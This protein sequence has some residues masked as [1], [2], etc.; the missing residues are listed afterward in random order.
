[1]GGET[2]GVDDLGPGSEHL[3]RN[4]VEHVPAIVYIGSNDAPPNTLYISPQIADLLGYSPEDWIHGQDWPASVH[5]EDAD[6]VIGAWRE[7][8]ET[9]GPFSEEYRILHR[10]GHVVWGRDSARLIRDGDGRP[11]FWQ[12]VFQD[13]SDGNRAERQSRRSERRYRALVEQLPAIV[14]VDSDDLQ[15]RSL[16]VSPNVV[17]LLGYP[18]Q[19]Y[20]DDPDLW[21]RSMHPDD[22][23]SVLADWQEA[24]R[25]SEPFTAEYRIVRP[26]G[27]SLWVRDSSVPL[28]DKEGDVTYWQGVM[29]DIT[30]LTRAERELHRSEARYR[31]LVEGIPAVIYEMDPDDER[32]T[33]YVSPQVVDV[34]GYS[35]QEWLDQPDIWTELLHP[36][37]REIELAALDLHN[38]TGEPW[39]RDYRLIANDGRVVWV[40]DQAALVQ[41]EPGRREW[42]GVML[43]ITA[44]K[45]AE[46]RLMRANDELE[47][48]VLARTS[49]LTEANEMMALE[50][51]ERRRV[52]QE[53]RESQ[54]RY[55]QLVEHLP[56]V[57]FTWQAG[58]SRFDPS[59]AYISPQLE[60][61]LGYTPAEWGPDDRTWRERLHP[62][63]GARVVAAVERSAETGAPFNE[64]YRLFA[65]DG[66]LVWILDRSSMLS[67]T[68]DGKPDLFQGVMLDITSTRAAEAKAD[69]AQH[70]F[71]TLA[72]QG[73]VISYLFEKVDIP[74][75]DEPQPAVTY[76]SPQMEA[77]LGYPRER[78]VDEPMLWIHIIHPDDLSRILDES[79]RAW[80]TGEPWA[81]DMRMIAQDG[82]VVWLYG[83]GRCI[84]RDAQGA[85]KA[86]HG[87][88]LDISR[89]KEAE[90]RLRA[91]ELHHR[92]LLARIPGIP[93]IELQ[94]DDSSTDRMLFL[95][96]QVE[97]ILGW[98]PEELLREPG[99]FRRMV[100]PDDRDRVLA[101]SAR[102]DATG[103]PWDCEYRAT[104]KDGRI[105][106]MQSRGYR[107]VE[108]ERT[109]WY[110]IT[111]DITA[112]MEREATAA[113]SGSEVS[114]SA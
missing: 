61:I 32:R 43:D 103:E 38:Q 71:A 16:Y 91:S 74:G 69:A 20:L 110:G 67:R 83:Q 17:D 100:H 84:E 59:R 7:A 15:P 46:E 68:P 2:L 112:R 47:F 77:V 31:T 111:M 18:V 81:M 37:D 85:P 107:V 98:T 97:E 35:R 79:V 102:C 104:T 12:G 86:F 53:L 66:R 78:F 114:P 6:R 41:A 105:V 93:W 73:P 1:M 51:G 45:T 10:D 72:E 60:T 99:H 4:L 29:L 89:R 13:V 75:H 3:F 80:I 25:T 42:H 96:D 8:V 52:E 95:G 62:H 101:L 54:E 109:L 11:V 40:R 64:E 106:W 88:M 21:P 56:G 82:H 55:R 50:I 87:T 63:D 34:L 19:A 48:R 65:K 26:D 5:P 113:P 92:T 30:A 24:I 27:T 76:V 44:Q 49:E 9:G 23:D 70:R 58:A 57:A 14:Y 94:G 22:R 108:A 36:D 28:R 39:S 33:V 90:E